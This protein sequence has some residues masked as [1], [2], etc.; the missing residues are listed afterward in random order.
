ML[1]PWH[2]ASASHL[3][4]LRQAFKNV[5]MRPSGAGPLVMLAYTFRGGAPP[6]GADGGAVGSAGG[7]VGAGTA[8]PGADDAAAGMLAGVWTMKLAWGR[9]VELRDCAVGTGAGFDLDEVV[10]SHLPPPPGRGVVVTVGVVE[11]RDGVQATAQGQ[12]EGRPAALL[13]PGGDWMGPTFLHLRAGTFDTSGASCT[14]FG[15]AAFAARAQAKEP[16][17]AGL[18]NKLNG[19]LAESSDK[20]E[21]ERG[22]SGR[23]WG[24]G[25]SSLIR[26]FGGFWREGTGR[27]LIQRGQ[28]NA[29]AGAQRQ[30]KKGL[31]VIYS[32]GSNVL[33][34]I[35]QDNHREGRQ[36]E[37]RERV[38]PVQIFGPPSPRP[39]P[40]GPSLTSFMN[41]HA[42]HLTVAGRA[43]ANKS[44]VHKYSATPHTTY[45]V[46]KPC[47]QQD[48]KNVYYL[49]CIPLESLGL[50]REGRCRRPH[51]RRWRW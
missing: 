6:D 32:R 12:F 42:K 50:C 28:K 44:S 10:A 9:G 30:Q 5:C 13:Y 35:T 51:W 19:W 25:S 49:S 37:E 48:V 47:M 18:L 46:V 27:R 23:S 43:S 2:A 7:A 41:H 33:S 26:H 39:P 45:L 29:E 17:W 16:L 14:F 21:E 11:H 8:G 20:A 22:E 4:H 15:R 3:P 31:V 36:E 34:V 40:L 38:R 1:I 24:R